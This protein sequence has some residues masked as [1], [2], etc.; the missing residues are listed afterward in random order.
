MGFFGIIM[1]SIAAQLFIFGSIIQRGKSEWI[2]DI[3]LRDI[4]DI[5]GYCRTFGN[6]LILL[7]FIAIIC[8]IMAFMVSD[9][10]LKPIIIFG[11]GIL[12]VLILFYIDHKKFIK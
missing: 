11:A 10:N 9:F 1:F 3:F 4:K 5:Q 6:K 8:G 12:L 2:S 7:N